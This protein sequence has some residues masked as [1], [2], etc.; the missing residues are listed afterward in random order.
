[1]FE[2]YVQQE[3]SQ[4]TWLYDSQTVL[5]RGWFGSAPP[6]PGL[7]QRIGDYILVM[8]ENW[9]I[10]DWLPGEQRHRQIG[11]HGGISPDEMT[12]PLIVTQL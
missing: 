1:M 6:H 8:K 2:T 9:T 5:E 11:V 10:K 12:V 3:L 7:G 4:Q